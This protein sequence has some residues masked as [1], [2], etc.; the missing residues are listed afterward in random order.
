ME[1]LKYTIKGAFIVNK[2]NLTSKYNI[3][4]SMMIK[5]LKYFIIES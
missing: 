3:D 4:L 1:T 2:I 5:N